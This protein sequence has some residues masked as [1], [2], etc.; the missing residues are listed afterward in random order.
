M[1]TLFVPIIIA[2]REKNCFARLEAFSRERGCLIWMGNRNGFQ[3]YPSN[4]DELPMT[5]DL[6]PT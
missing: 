2:K 5:C 6:S 4:V 1:E 3:V